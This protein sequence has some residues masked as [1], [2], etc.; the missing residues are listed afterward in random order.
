MKHAQNAQLRA[1]SG[2]ELVL[3]SRRFLLVM[4]IAVVAMFVVALNVLA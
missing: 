1:Q 4:Q 3:L 2:E